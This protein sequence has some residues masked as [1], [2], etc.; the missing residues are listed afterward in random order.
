MEIETVSNAGPSEGT[1][2]QSEG[3]SGAS[4]QEASG[5][6]MAEGNSGQN[7]N[8]SAADQAGLGQNNGTSELHKIKYGKNERELSI[9]ELKMLAQKGWAADDRFQQAAKMKKEIE[10]LVKSAKWNDLIQKQTGKPA[11]EYYKDQI[12]AEIRRRNMSPEEREAEERQAKIE[13][14]RNEEKELVAAKTERQLKEQEEHYAQQWDKE[15]ADAIK[16]EGLPVNRYALNRAVQIAKK[17]V[18]MGLDP[19]WGLV[20]KEAKSQMQDDIKQLLTAYKDDAAL[21]SFLGDEFG[22][23]ISKAMVNRKSPANKGIQRPVAAAGSGDSFRQKEA[24]PMDVDEWI[25]SRRK[26]FE[27]G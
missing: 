10:S 24:K 1:S 16:K 2:S 6:G 19:D 11:L 26:A 15:F 27:E 14:L 18:A 7:Q 4:S 13:A 22:L 17:V 3:Q 9:D 5:S 21:L 20:V 25:A 12:K 23:R 8:K